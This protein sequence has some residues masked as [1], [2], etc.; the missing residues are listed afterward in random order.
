MS[1]IAGIEAGGKTE[2]VERMLSKIDYRGNGETIVLADDIATTGT[3]LSNDGKREKRLNQYNDV[4]PSLNTLAGERLPFAAAGVVNNKLI[5]TRDRVGVRPLYYGYTSEGDFCYA[6]EVKALMEATEDIHEF[7]PG[8]I[9]ESGKG[10]VEFASIQ[11]IPANRMSAEDAAIGLHQKLLSAILARVDSSVMG[12]WLSGGIDSSVI[13]SLVRP[14]V[15]TL[16]TFAAGLPGAPDVKF[17]K[18]VADHVKTTHH[19]VIISENELPSLLDE[20]IFA[21]ESFDAL[22]VRSTI[23]NYMVSK[24]AKDYVGSVFSGEGGDELFAGYEYI[25]Q[26]PAKSIPAELVDITNRLHNTALQRVD[27]SSS[28]NGLVAHVPFVDGEVLN[29]ALTIPAEYK[30][31]QGNPPIEKWILRKAME[32]DLPESVLWRKKAKFWEGSGVG[33]MLSGYA[34]ENITDSDFK[35]ERMIRDGWKLNTKEEL[36]YFR[37]FNEHFGHLDDLS[38]MGRTKGAPI[39]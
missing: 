7:L 3:N 28:A 21:L 39:E 11:E 26:L 29:F 20:V 10:F 12:S 30:L 18:V 9:Y 32:N 36:L 1:G 33:G 31:K 6:S 34:E 15:K 17:A 2:I 13:V 35:S 23:M 16:H 25:Q 24:V 14:L 4:I 5:L 19:E 8:H 37:F 38:W 27:R 22:L